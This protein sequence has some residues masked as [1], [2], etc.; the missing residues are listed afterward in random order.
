MKEVYLF[1]TDD[2]GAPA[3]HVIV[4]FVMHDG[5]LLVDRGIVP[6]EKV[7]PATRRGGQISGEAHFVGVWRMPDPP[8]KPDRPISAAQRRGRV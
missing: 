2:A 6:K 5:T 1:G 4:P 7:N 3:Y 8:P